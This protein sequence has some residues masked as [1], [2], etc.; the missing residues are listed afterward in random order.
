MTSDS[1]L[2]YRPEQ[3][4]RDAVA[5][6]VSRREQAEVRRRRGVHA[7]AVIGDLR[8]YQAG[9]AGVLQLFHADGH[10]DVHGTAGDGVHGGAQR[11]GARGAHVLHPRDRLTRQPQRPGQRHAADPRYVGA[12]PVRVDVVAGQAGSVQRVRDSI[13]GELIRAAVEVLRESG[14]AHRDDR[15]T[16]A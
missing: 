6:L 3:F 14:A 5:L 8:R 11:L 9:V 13:D 10:G 7:G 2:M 16:I 4:R 15:D 12:Q 1:A